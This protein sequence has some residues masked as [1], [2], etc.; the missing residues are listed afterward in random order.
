VKGLDLQ[1]HYEV[2]EVSPGAR[3]EE[4]ERAYRLASATWAEGSLALYSLFEDTDAAVVRERLGDAYL[5]LS[6]ER[7][8]RAYDAATFETP[9]DPAPPASAPGL[10]VDADS[11]EVLEGAYDDIEISLDSALEGRVEGAA[12]GND[13]DFDGARLRRARMHR[14]VELEEIGRVTK[15]T[16]MYLQAIEDEAFDTLPAAVYARGFVTAYARAI[17]LDPKRVADSY[18][19]R[20]EAASKG[21]GRGRLLGRG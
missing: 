3:P 9:P 13:A 17:G 4:I 18:M 8:R 21:Q 5:T 20:F 11:L 1:N 19:P 6:D 7:A 12:E 16:L 14:G 2:L 10:A 15:V